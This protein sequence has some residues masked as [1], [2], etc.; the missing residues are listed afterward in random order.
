MTI[1]YGLAIG[2]SALVI[3]W[4]ALAPGS[5]LHAQ[6]PAASSTLQDPCDE[7]ANW[8]VAENCK[9]GNPSIEWD[10]NG[11]GDATILG[12]ATDI[13]Y[14][15]VETARIKTDTDSGYRIDIY[16]AGYY[17]GLGARLVDT[18][19]PAVASPQEQP[20][21]ATDWSVRLYDCGTWSESAAWS[22]PDDAV[23][24]VYVARLVRED[25]AST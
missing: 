19:E 6:A 17:N 18:V 24:G 2:V 16:R 14:N 21:C 15:V 11:N 22:I 7:P 4:G 12:F 25:G 23:S 9:S 20:P 3:T 1:T 8:I 10:V 5:A 13:S